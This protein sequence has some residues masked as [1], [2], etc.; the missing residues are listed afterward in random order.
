MQL[1]RRTLFF[2]L[3]LAIFATDASLLSVSYFSARDALM[4]SLREQGERLRDGYRVGL[5]ATLNNMLQ[6]ATFVANDDR[7]AALFLAGRRAVEAEGGGAGGVQAAAARARLLAEVGPAWEQMTQRFDARQLHF[8]IAP[9]SLSF[10]RVHQPDRFGDRMDDIRQI[11]VDVNDDLIP[12]SGFETGRIYSGIRGVVPVFAQVNG[13]RIHVGAVEVGTSFTELFR[14]IDEELGVGIAALLK[15][16]HVDNSMWQEFVRSHFARVNEACQCAIEATSRP[17]V[18]ALITAHMQTQGDT[19]GQ[20]ETHLFELG[21]HYVAATHWPLF[22][23][24]AQRHP[25]TPPVGAILAWRTVDAE[26]MAFQQAMRSNLA[27]A[28]IG[29]VLLEIALWGTTRLVTGRLEREVAERTTQLHQANARLE[30][31][32]TRDELTRI[33]NRRHLMTLLREEWER[34]RRNGEPLCFALLDLD[35]FKMV[36]DT[37]GHISGDRVLHNVAQVVA[38]ESRAYDIAGRYGGEELGL[39]LPGIG[40]PLARAVCERVRQAVARSSVESL[41]GRS[42]GI[43]VSIGL[44]L[45]NDKEDIE[46]V[47]ATADAGLYEAKRSGR[48]RV[49]IAGQNGVPLAIA[50]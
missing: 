4:E 13:E 15:R 42:I 48:N 3:S 32:A 37:H 36:N 2:L 29:F 19:F 46:A 41:E 18:E 5:S 22:D 27:I 11:I 43:T 33:Y 31:L 1:R 9:G 40:L 30:E 10:L 12:R 14:V 6:M 23:Y 20:L 50:Q 47:I 8:H 25:D 45:V 7:L 38:S 24:E 28:V 21:E 44:T 26:V 34:A 35:H 49:A 16:E 17:G 39:I